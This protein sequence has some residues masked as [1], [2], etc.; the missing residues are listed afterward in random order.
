MVELVT[1][2]GGELVLAYNHSADRRSPLCLRYSTDGAR[3]WST[4]VIV[5]S[6][7]GEFSYPCMIA[8]SD[9]RVHLVYTNNRRTITY[10]RFTM[11]MLSCTSER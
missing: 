11:D 7:D 10:A 8:G 9:G 1:L 4:P 3:T 5:A 2:P 6:G